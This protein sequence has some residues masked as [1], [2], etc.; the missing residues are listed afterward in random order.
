MSGLRVTVAWGALLLLVSCVETERALEPGL[1]DVAV[2]ATQPP[3]YAP[4]PQGFALPPAPDLV[5]AEPAPLPVRHA[6]RVSFVPAGAQRLG[7]VQAVQVAVAVTG[8][9]RGAREV[10]VNFVS[11]PGLAWERQA[12][13]LDPSATPGGELVFTLP[14][15][16]T[17]IEEQRL[18]GRWSLTTL[19]DGAE[20]AAASFEVLP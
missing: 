17:L 6:V 12:R 8:G 13:L 5:F 18:F 11:P 4:G 14:V 1:R 9:P 15:A 20:A 3:V 2:V 10:T 16:A 7:E 19:D